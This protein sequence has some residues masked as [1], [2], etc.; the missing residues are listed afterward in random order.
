MNKIYKVVWSKLKSCYV[1]T[2]EF[3]KSRTKSS[4]SG[5]RAGKAAVAAVALTAFLS[6]TGLAG[7][8]HN[9]TVDSDGK[10]PSGTAVIAG[11]ASDLLTKTD[12]NTTYL[13]KADAGTTY[14]TKA[15]AN[16][17]Y[18]T[19]TDLSKEETD[20]KLADTALDGRIGQVENKTT[21]ISYN[22]GGGTNVDGVNI[23]SGDMSGVTKINDITVNNNALGNIS[24]L[25][26]TGDVKV[27]GDLTV[28]GKFMPD[29]VLIKDDHNNLTDIKAGSIESKNANFTGDIHDNTIEGSK[30]NF[31]TNGFGVSA[32]GMGPT[33]GNGAEM[34]LQKDKISQEVLDA[35]GNSNSEVNTSTKST[36]TVTNGTAKTTVEQTAADINLT[37]EDGNINN[38]AKN[39]TNTTTE[40]MT[41]T[42]GKD[43]TTTVGGNQSTAVGG[44][45]S[46]DV[47]GNQSNTV[48]GHQSNTVSGNLTESVAGDVTEDYKANQ[49]TKVGG[50]RT[51][52]VEGDVVEY[53]KKDQ[54]TTVDGNQGTD[55][56]GDQTNTVG[57][58]LTETV[59]GDVTEDYKAN[60]TT[61]VG[62]NQST[63]VKGDQ[64][65]T[66]GG[67]LTETVTGDVTED[68]KANQTTKVG[69]NQS[70]DVKGDQTNT[71]GGKLTETVT[72]DVTEDYKANQT[73]KVGGNQSTDVKGDQ[74]NTV[75]GKLT[76]TVTGDVTEDY[77]AN[78]TTKVGGNQSTD[79]KGDQTNTVG[80]KLTE[81]VTGDV[82]E[83][84]KANQTTTVDKNQTTKVGGDQ[85]ID[86]KGDQTNT[87]G[88]KLTET[89]EG[90]VVE[91]YKG[92]QTTTIGG[93]QATDVAGSQSTTVGGDRITDVKGDDVLTAENITHTAKTQLINKVGTT[94]M[95]MTVTNTTFNNDVVM[96]NNLDVAGDVKAAS[97]KIGSKTYIDND[98]INANKQ[99]I[100]NVADGTLSD[101]SLDAVNGS[102]LFRTNQRI[103]R[104]N[105]DLSRVGA[106]AAA[107]AG[108]HPVDYDATSKLSFAVGFG[109]Y[110]SEHAAAIGAFYRPNDNILFG[111]SST[112]GYGDNMY[113][114][115]LSFKFGEGSHERGISKAAQRKIDTLQNKVSL[116]EARLDNILNIFNPNAYKDFPDIP[117]NHWAYE[118]V[119][120]LAGNGIVEGY[121]DGDYHGDRTMTR[122]EMAMIIYNAL[123]RG[124]QADMKL[125][126]E[127]QPELSMIEANTQ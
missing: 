44:D 74:T 33:G 81:T 29:E 88:G 115:S 15:D 10:L 38:K 105:R 41:N 119:S 97:Y 78:Q 36:H 73:T 13:T 120:T 21:N 46:T 109:S 66:V 50:D 99:K 126:R 92:D 58:K 91:D 100:I 121:P 94:S 47:T 103:E 54:T 77:K 32:V 26:T 62:G 6:C 116:L 45:Q 9:V 65:N 24:T 86:V 11:E 70:T 40:D 14:L 59:T 16:T 55:V 114:A 60:Q 110:K 28:K 61:K 76:E 57:G 5:K 84:Y 102:Q 8:A 71:V 83:D 3:G 42:I 123:K 67:K 80:G 117:E 4:G 104:W 17:N 18:A 89:V 82:E 106:G 23:K 111:V 68:Y 95:T 53:Y 19:K 107:L 98:G 25:E 79:V 48:S 112:V 125:V 93:N 127:F 124:V 52:T 20:R 39:I 113:N 37:A 22:A 85:D 87:V 31:D 7:A 1:V 30:L 56:K 108:L 34:K 96:N 69:G 122:Y 64:T 72:G 12:A 63:D 51:E 118:A 27:G 101:T 75:G 49:T 2:S 43:L 35:K 90:D